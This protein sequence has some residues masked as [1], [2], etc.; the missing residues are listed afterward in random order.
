MLDVQVVGRSGAGLNVG[1]SFNLG[2][3]ASE[4]G[5][6]NSG[7]GFWSINAVG[8][9]LICTFLLVLT[10]TPFEDKSKFLWSVSGDEG[11]SVVKRFIRRG[12]LFS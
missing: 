12:A 8:T 9:S 7:G 5:L 4:L 11:T 1:A 2:V 10:L 6:K 3:Y